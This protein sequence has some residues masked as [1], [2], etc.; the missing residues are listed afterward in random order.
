[1]IAEAIRVAVRA[2]FGRA[3]E[4]RRFSRLDIVQCELT[5]VVELLLNVLVKPTGIVP[6]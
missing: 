3:D 6:E 4:V 5:A 2:L 1:M